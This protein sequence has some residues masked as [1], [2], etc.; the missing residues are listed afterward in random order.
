MAL[1]D[2][3]EALVECY[4]GQGM[5]F[6]EASEAATDWIRALQREKSGTTWTLGPNRRG[7]S[8]TVRKF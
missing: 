1:S 7:V 6:F 3:K 2:V 4:Q 5:G 8:V